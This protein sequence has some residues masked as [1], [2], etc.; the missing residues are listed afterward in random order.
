[1]DVYPENKG[2]FVPEHSPEINILFNRVFHKNTFRFALHTLKIAVPQKI[3]YCLFYHEMKKESPFFK[4][5]PSFFRK[6]VLWQ[7]FL[8][9]II[10][11]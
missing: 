9:V 7:Q 11:L 5:I 8:E 2:I 1:M 6:I 10:Y 3:V 4:G